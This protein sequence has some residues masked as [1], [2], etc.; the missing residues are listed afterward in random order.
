L[1]ECKLMTATRSPST[2]FCTLWP[3]NLDPWPFDLDLILHGWPGLVMDYPVASL[4]IVVSAVLVLSCGQTDTHR[5]IDAD[6]CLTPTTLVGVSNNKQNITI[7]LSLANHIQ[8]ADLLILADQSLRVE[9]SAN[10]YCWP[11]INVAWRVDAEWQV[12]L[13]LSIFI[14]RNVPQFI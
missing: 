1:I 14:G 10:L 3:C 11:L 2:C 13:L 7:M 4:V 12:L 5:H 6:K 8:S 9:L